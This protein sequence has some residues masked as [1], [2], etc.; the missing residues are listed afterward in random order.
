MT[1]VA[2]DPLE[3]GKGLSKSDLPASRAVWTF[4]ARARRRLDFRGRLGFHP[5]VDATPLG[6]VKAG[7]HNSNI[8]IASGRESKL[9]SGHAWWDNAFLAPSAGIVYRA[10]REGFVPRHWFPL[11]QRERST[12]TARGW[13]WGPRRVRAGQDGHGPQRRA[14][15]A[16]GHS[17]VG[18]P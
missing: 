10:G 16:R 4:W 6:G 3:W 12:S 9:R 1:P 11:R 2:R 15:Q 7:A 18:S 14:A 8:L 5:V 17:R 13:V